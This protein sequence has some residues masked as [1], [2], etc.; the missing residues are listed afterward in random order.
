MTPIYTSNRYEIQSEGSG[1]RILVRRL[2]DNASFFMQDEDAVEFL[3]EGDYW[4]SMED[5]DRVISQYED[6][7][8]APERPDLIHV[9]I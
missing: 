1:A 7:F 9:G 4:V 5:G 2:A 6:L 8:V 3:K